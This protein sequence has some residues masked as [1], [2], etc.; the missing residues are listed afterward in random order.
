M[1]VLK[2]AYWVQWIQEPKTVAS[3]GSRDWII[4]IT[5]KEETNLPGLTLNRSTRK[6]PY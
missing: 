6:V 5:S 4:F 1:H 3:A 2:L